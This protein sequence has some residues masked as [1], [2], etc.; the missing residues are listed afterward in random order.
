MRLLRRSVALKVWRGSSVPQCNLENLPEGGE[1]RKA[2]KMKTLIIP[3]RYCYID[4]CPSFVNNSHLAASTGVALGGFTTVE[5]IQ[6]LVDRQEGTGV[7]AAYQIRKEI[8]RARV[9]VARSKNWGLSP[10]KGDKL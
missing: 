8:E 9:A 2:Q 3:C 6:L 1:T 7:S 4:R 10:I 5:F